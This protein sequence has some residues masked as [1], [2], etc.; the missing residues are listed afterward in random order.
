[1]REGELHEVELKW[2]AT[3]SEKLQRMNN[4]IGGSMTNKMVDV[5][6]WRRPATPTLAADIVG[7]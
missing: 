5:G 6:G 3:Y 1:M 2:T 4:E 7:H